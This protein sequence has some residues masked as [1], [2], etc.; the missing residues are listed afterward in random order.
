MNRMTICLIL[1][2]LLLLPTGI[3]SAEEVEEIDSLEILTEPS[4]W[5]PDLWPRD[6]RWI[7]LS[8]GRTIR[9]GAW[10]FTVTHRA[11]ESLDEEPGDH[12][13]GLDSGSLKVGLGVR[14]SPWERLDLGLQRTNGTAEVFDTYEMDARFQLLDQVDQG[15]DLALRGGVSWFAQPDTEDASG[16]FGQLLL[17]RDLGHR[18]RLGGGLLFHA[19][20]SS[21]LKSTEDD[22]ESWGVAAAGEL[23]LHPRLAW[24]VESAWNVS[25]YGEEEPALATSLKLRTHR[26]TFSVVLSNT[27]YTGADGLPTGAWREPDDLLIG[28][29]I[30]REI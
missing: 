11:W 13:L 14:Y 10:L 18:I 22:E 8:Q 28:F 6:D 16:A 19:D 17:S 12:G 20:S 3:C 29:N 21:D 30:T 27:Q 9:P 24:L 15:I 25:G 26:H 4:P 2:A 7:N 1:P 23:W 5:D